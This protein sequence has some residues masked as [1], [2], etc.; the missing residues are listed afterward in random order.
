[1]SKRSSE[2]EGFDPQEYEQLNRVKRFEGNS[3]FRFVEWVEW[4]EDLFAVPVESFFDWKMI[5][6]PED[7]FNIEFGSVLNPKTNDYFCSARSHGLDNR[8]FIRIVLTVAHFVDRAADNYPSN[9]RHRERVS[10]R[11]PDREHRI[12]IPSPSV[13]SL[14][15]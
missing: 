1:M 4:Q 11:K 7:Y 13:R 12:F 2:E 10:R 15:S 14:L 5:D 6:K 8:D 3:Y 9:A